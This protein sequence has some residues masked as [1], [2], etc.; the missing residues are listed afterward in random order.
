MFKQL[1]NIMVGVIMVASPVYV[2]A[3]IPVVKIGQSSFMSAKAPAKSPADGLVINGTGQTASFVVD[4]QN[5]C[6]QITLTATAGLKVSPEVLPAD[7]RNAS[8]EVTLLSTLPT[9]EGKIILRSGDYRYVVNVLGYGSELEQKDLSMNPVYIGNDTRFTNSASDGFAPGE[10]GYTVEFRAN[11]GAREHI[12]V[13]GVT[14]KGQSFKAYVEEEEIG[15]YNSTEKIAFGNP[16]TAVDGGKSQFYNNDGKAHT[17]RFSVTSDKRV[18]AYR[19]GIQVAS[20]RAADYAN[21]ADWALEN[22]DAVENLL[23]NSDFEGEWNI[24]ESDSLVNKVEG[25]RLEPIDQYN[26][27]YT[28]INKE[29]DKEHDYF[30]HVMNLQRYNWNDGWAAGTVSQIVDVAPNS[31]YSLSFLASAGIES[32]TKQLMGEVRIQEV[33]DSK[34]GESVE[35]TNEGELKPYGFTYTTSADC[36]QIKVILYNERFVNGGG[37]GSSPQPFLVDDIVLSGTSRVIDQKVGFDLE[38]SGMEYFTYDVTGAYA[39]L[40]PVLEPEISNV[41]LDGFGTSKTIKVNIANLLGDDKVTVTATPGFMVSPPELSASSDGEITV[42]LNSTMPE[43]EGN[44]ILR[45]G[46]LRTYINLVGYHEGLERKDLSANPIYDGKSDETL[47][48]AASDGFTPG[49]NGYTVEFKV[50]LDS[51]NNSF[52]TY[53]VTTEGSSFKAYVEPNELGIYNSTEKISIPNPLTSADG[54][55]SIFYNA[56]GKPHTYRYAVTPDKR[57]YVY[58]DGL[59]VAALRADDYANQS[60]WAVENGDMVENLLKNG[61]FEGEW[62][63]RKDGL[64]NNVE[65][66]IVNPID[67]YNCK[68]D[69]INKEINQDLDIDN[70]VM[71]LQRYNWNDGWGAGTVSQIVDV[72]PN[73]TYSLSFLASA[74]IE[75][76]TKQL[77]GEVKIQEVQDPHLGD[78]VEIT[79]EGDLKPY[80]FTYTTTADCKQIKVILYN[81]RFVNGGGWGSSP[82]PFIVDE[83]VLSG[84]SRVLD[85]KVGYEMNGMT[86]NLLEYFTYDATGAYAPMKPGFGDDI[87]ESGIESVEYGSDISVNVV[88]EGVVLLNTAEGSDVHVY[89]MMGKP[90][91]I[92]KGYEAGCVISLPGH[93]V[94]ICTVSNGKSSKTIKVIY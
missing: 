30:N 17:Y 89:D 60:E 59:Q 36:K 90:V 86:A 61:D 21:Q 55:K 44:V 3:S 87:E 32:K 79:N 57:I 73:S 22:G 47:S 50:Q 54:G 29:L 28:V 18:F 76:K 62:G 33:Q 26:C 91:I 38:G 88:S 80:G 53:A 7:A 67:Q 46:D 1:T 74:G 69:V 63:V 8:V 2:S 52:D 11:L 70:H 51:D 48:H 81:E 4:A 13:F 64:V 49:K 68:Y 19:D 16:K 94:Y 27:K 37:W 43:T 78:S 75:S 56:D 31:T 20:L 12:D 25:W 10:S 35:I 66:W 14:P 41:E 72:A 42:T 15:L 85:Q 23:K 40:V 93:G 39:P 58:R 77:M 84:T 24:R 6:D 65:G 5:L 83:M 45:N 34:L 82:Q 9:T 92:L 71:R